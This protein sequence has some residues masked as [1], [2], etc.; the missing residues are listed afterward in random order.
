MA[1]NDKIARTK[2]PDY[3][4]K[5]IEILISTPTRRNLRALQKDGRVARTTADNK[6]RSLAD[7]VKKLRC[8]VLAK[9]CRSC[10]VLERNLG[11]AA[12]SVLNSLAAVAPNSR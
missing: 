6:E 5:A 11:R 2:L 4:A 7:I 9:T 12:A 1:E 8:K 3:V 10:I